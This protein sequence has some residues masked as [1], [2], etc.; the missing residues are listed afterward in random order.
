MLNVDNKIAAYAL[1]TRLKKVIAEIISV[2]QNG[3]IKNRFIG[4][5][6]RQ[7]DDII[8]YSEKFDIDCSVLFLDFRKAFDTIEWDF[9]IESLRKFG[10]GESFIGWINTL[11]KNITG[12]VTNNNWISEPYIIQRGIRQGCPLSCLIF[13]IAVEIMATNIRNNKDI[14]GFTIGRKTMKMSQIADDTTLFL[15]YG[16]IKHAISE[17]ERFGRYSGLKLNKN[18]CEGIWLGRNKHRKETMGMNISRKEVKSLGIY[19]GANRVKTELLNWEKI[20]DAVDVLIKNWKKRK[21][22][23][24]GKIVI[25]KTLII[26]KITYYSSVK[27][28]DSAKVKDLESSLYKFIW[29]DKVDKVKRKVLISSFNE[30]GLCMR[31]LESHID[32]LRM[33][34]VKRL[35][36]ERNTDSNWII[37]PKHYL[38]VQGLSVFNMN[39]HYLR[40]L[41]NANTIPLFYKNIL[42]TWILSKKRLKD[43]INDF[44]NEILWGNSKIIYKGKSLFFKAWIESGIMRVKDLC[45]T[46]TGRLDDRFIYG[47]LQRRYNWM[48]ELTIIRLSLPH[49]WLDKIKT[50]I[51]F[52]NDNVSNRVVLASNKIMYQNFVNMKK[53]DPV[54]LNFWKNTFSVDNNVMKTFFKFIF[55]SLH[56]NKLKMFKWKLFHNILP[57]GKNLKRW[58]IE[59]TDICRKCGECDDIEH[60]FVT[61]KGL[62]H[63]WHDVSSN[64]KRIGVTE[65]LRTTLCMVLGHRLNQEE[66]TEV[67]FILTILGYSIFKAYCLSENRREY[68]NMSSLFFND[69]KFYNNYLEHVK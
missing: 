11:Y 39:L 31:D 3:Y 35:L 63:L 2:D 7:I 8:D 34:W 62:D 26:P 21:L 68:I 12:C 49:V 43:E 64:F 47:K 25:I 33:T 60:F 53:C 44:Q 18:K 14:Q 67:N 51:I 27:S 6:I 61:C 32:M 15:K 9:M 28:V 10:F 52:K 40:H 36:D 42:E 20:V 22:T 4:F 24:L 30:G 38:T 41:P 69:L 48:S 58:K 29:D 5:N 13:L 46:E 23:L 57:T 54:Y 16:D 65:N 66:Y 50:G 19:F 55:R 37:L 45:N 17:V 1:A 56:D 59:E